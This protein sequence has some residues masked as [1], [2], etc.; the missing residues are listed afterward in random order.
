MRTRAAASGRLAASVLSVLLA[1]GL[2]AQ[3]AVLAR[4]QTYRGTVSVARTSRNLAVSAR[5]FPLVNGDHVVTGGDGSARVVSVDGKRATMGPNSE[6]QIGSTAKGAAWRASAGRVVVWLTGRGRTEVA[7]PAA[8][9]AAEGTGFELLVAADGTSTLTVAEGTVQW[10]NDLGA[11][12]VVADQQST[13]RPGQAPTRPIA[14]DASGVRLFEATVENVALPLESPRLPGPRDRLP[15]LLTE[16]QGTAQGAPND[17]AAQVALGD[18]Q[19]DLGQAAEA[20]ASYQRARRLAPMDPV[21]ADRAS[22]AALA[23]GRSDVAREAA[24]AATRLQPEGPVASLARGRLLLAEGNAAEAEPLLRRAEEAAPERGEAAALLGLARLRL[25]R[26]AEAEAA[27]RDAVR[28]EPELYAPHAYL[29]SALV[30]QGRTADAEGEAR[31][32]LALAPDSALAHEALGTVFLFSGRADEAVTELRRAVAIDPLSGRASAQLAQAL[33]AADQ[34]EAAEVEAAR[35]VSLDPGDAGAR[36]TLGTFFAA[37]RDL[38]RAAREF[39]EALRIAPDT[40]SARTGLSGV[41]IQRGRFGRALQTQEAALDLDTGSPQAYNNLG[42][43]YTAR[44]RLHEA[45]DAFRAALRLQPGYA[46]AHGNMAVAYLELNEYAQALREGLAALR[47][48]ER[49]PILHTTLA[50]IYIRQGRFDRAQAELRRSESL[51]PYYPLQFFYLAQLYRLQG[52]D[53]DGIR[54]LLRGLTLDPGTAAEQR[55]YA[56]TETTNAGGNRG[57]HHDLRT[58]GRTDAGRL[59]YFVS[60]SEDDRDAARPNSDLRDRF[61]E[62]ILGYQPD[63][64]HN[65]VLFTSHLDERGGRP[66]RLRSNGLVEDPNFRRDFTAGNVQILDRVDLGRR[67]FLTFDGGFRRS[68]VFGENPANRDRPDPFFV[69]LF[70]TTRRDYF[71]EAELETALGRDDVLRTGVSFTDSHRDFTGIFP[72]LSSPGAF[73]GASSAERPTLFTG[74]AEVRR[75]FGPR[76]DLTLGAQG[77]TQSRASGLIRPKV[78]AHYRAGGNST[79][80]FLAYPIFQQDTADLLPVETWEQPFETGPLPL[81]EGGA[82]MN[83]ELSWERPFDAASLFSGVGFYRRARGLLV[84]TVDPD[85]APLVARFPVLDGEVWGGQLAY[86][87]TL[88]SRLTTRVFARYT[89]TRDRETGKELPYFPRWQSG[90]R[91][92]FVNRAGIRARLGVT[93]IGRRLDVQAPDDRGR[94]LGGFFST[95][96]RVSWQQNL[97]VNYFVQLDDLFDRGASFYGGYPAGG[98]SFL[99]GID[100]RL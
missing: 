9:A 68:G 58:D 73:F 46:I 74:W 13:A 32:A 87:R 50:R 18:V 48:G 51:D 22:L 19:L 44:G 84:S 64:R 26:T 72:D 95:D 8:I 55:Q 10:F 92:D 54:A 69:R 100:L 6:L 41:E 5:N 7:T 88:A 42:V 34:V 27:L 12:Q 20:L 31:R 59:T 93:Y 3:T 94:H 99:V 96:F 40:A 89:G 67:S 61:I 16:R 79:F 23:L 75:Q 53:R 86:E 65:L 80:A 45:L 11:V 52:R 91:W 70:D 47:L 78:A 2:A 98:R 29:S 85:L 24:E 97:H 82:V 71:A 17:S 62:G 83:Y 4:I 76:L 37:R 1:S 90:I 30:L 38:N 25:R 36:I 77:A 49:S 57:H 33:A 14:V 39:G 43:I 56:R 63:D 60:G 15:A 21:P 66:G 81:L 28:R 35:A